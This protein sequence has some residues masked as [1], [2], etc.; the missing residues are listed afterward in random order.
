MSKI[1]NADQETYLSLNEGR[2]EGE[3]T[4]NTTVE[5]GKNLNIL[6]DGS[7]NGSVYIVPS[8][9]DDE[10][11]LDDGRRKYA[12]RLTVTEGER[13]GEDA[14][15]DR[16]ALPY[17]LA[18]EPPKSETEKFAKWRAGVKAYS[19][20][21]AEL[22]EKCGVDASETDAVQFTR[23]IAKNNLRKPTV[24]FTVKD[25]IPEIKRLLDKGNLDSDAKFDRE[26]SG[27]PDGNDAPFED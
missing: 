8:V 17:Y 1:Q 5:G 9:V 2:E 21:T 13:E 7:Y 27:L 19:S 26:N 10:K 12:I 23:N 3:S 11:S 25:G 16:V 6:P 18:N 15:L 20:L 4:T 14:F 24:Q 22:L